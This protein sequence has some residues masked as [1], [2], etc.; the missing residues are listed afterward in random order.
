MCPVVITL[1]GI[2]SSGEWQ[3]EIEPILNS[4]G[5]T[6]APLDYGYFTAY[7]L[8]L[9]WGVEKKIDWFRDEYRKIVSHYN[10]QRPSI[11]AHSFGSHILCTALERFNSEMKFDKIILAGS[12]VNRAY[13]WEKLFENDRVNEVHNYAGTRDNWAESAKTISYGNAGKCGFEKAIKFE[14]IDSSSLRKT[15]MVIEYTRKYAHSDALHRSLFQGDYKEILLNRY[16]HSREVRLA[17]KELL[18]NITRKL[19]ST[20]EDFFISF[21]DIRANI[22]LKMNDK[23]KIPKDFHYNY[24]IEE[25]E[26]LTIEFPYLSGQAGYVFNNP[27]SPNQDTNILIREY[28]QNN[29]GNLE[30]RQ[31][32][33]FTQIPER[34]LRKINKH[35]KHIISIPLVNNQIT[36][37]VLNIDILRNFC[38]DTREIMERLE[39]FFTQQIIINECNLIQEVL[40]SLETGVFQ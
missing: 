28:F 19:S 39:S 17:I 34:E 26:E 24:K 18:K 1:H 8:V 11:I 32:Q 12:I 30:P 3:R 7:S 22:F 6:H 5:I 14:T 20:L 16:T 13:D 40:S 4:Y 25:E 10:I 31:S 35:I 15:G 27:F 37:G 21:R 23:L 38:Y 36:L 2:R 9:R 29:F 33:I